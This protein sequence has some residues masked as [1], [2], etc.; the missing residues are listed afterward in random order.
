[1]ASSMW[2]LVRKKVVEV[3]RCEELRATKDLIREPEVEPLFQEDCANLSDVS[4]TCFP[5]MLACTKYL[6]IRE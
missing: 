1:M 6:A 5:R 4:A 3:R 2:C